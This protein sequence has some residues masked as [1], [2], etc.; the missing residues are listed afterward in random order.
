MWR[1]IMC[2]ANNIDGRS[3]VARL[4]ASVCLCVAVWVYLYRE[5]HKPSLWMPRLLETVK[6]W[7]A[8]ERAQHQWVHLMTSAYRIPR[9]RENRHESERETQHIKVT[10]SM[11]LRMN[12]RNAFNVNEIAYIHTWSS[13]NG[14]WIHSWRL[15]VS[16]RDSTTTTDDDDEMKRELQD[17]R[18]KQ[19][20]P[21]LQRNNDYLQLH[22]MG[23][24]Q[25]QP[26][27][28]W[29]RNMEILN[30]NWGHFIIKLWI[31]NTRRH[32][33]DNTNN[34]TDWLVCSFM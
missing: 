11:M 34:S 23:F 7:M 25:Q 16:G 19:E 12:D 4:S 18:W 3:S 8:H 17:R 2:V 15:S 1:W 9:K 33:R 24:T 31:W 28:H 6:L 30:H 10:H 14:S 29:T 20:D 22:S 27:H 32:W 21:P 26:C 5:T 13:L